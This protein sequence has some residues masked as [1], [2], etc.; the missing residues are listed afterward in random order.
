VILRPEIRYDRNW[1]SQPFEGK[2]DL[3]TA[4]TDLILRW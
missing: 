1:E 4:G 3:F 2:H